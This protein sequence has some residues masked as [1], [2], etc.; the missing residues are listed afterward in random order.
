MIDLY[1]VRHGE[2]LANAQ[3]RI[4]GHTDTP[5]SEKWMK[6]AQ[7]LKSFLE[8]EKLEIDLVYSSPLQRAYNTIDSYAKNNALSIMTD[9]RLKEIFLGNKEEK[10]VSELFSD[11]F[12]KN[13]FYYTES[14]WYESYADCTERV[15][16]FLLE[17][18]FSQKNKK[19]WFFLNNHIIYLLNYFCFYL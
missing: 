4:A 18:I 12:H 7:A 6:Q 8:S 16:W 15:R 17:H 11:E 10:L 1:L 13:P 14:G 2:S 3:W 19:I 9:E 5:L